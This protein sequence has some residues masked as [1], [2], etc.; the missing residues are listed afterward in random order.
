MNFCSVCG[1][2][3]SLIIP[4]GDDH[5]RH[6]C[7]DCGTIHYSNPN[8]V[9]GAILTQGDKILLCK[10]AIEPRYGLW[11]LPAGFMEN[12]ET[13][14]EG[15]ARETMEEANASSDNLKLFGVFS[16]PHIS[17]VYMMFKGELADG[18]HAPGAESLETALFSTDHIPWEQL[19]FP[20]IDYCL[21]LYL[22]QPEFE[23][24]H[25]ATA[26]RLADRKV[27]WVQR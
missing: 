20:V 23:G 26:I 25:M 8:N 1:K 24:V 10:R 3:V 21:K 15:A 12:G 14:T 9:C 5:L 22:Q 27:E 4:A 7:D 6:V 13:V 19:A 11:T 18:K 2:T 17:Q 16:L